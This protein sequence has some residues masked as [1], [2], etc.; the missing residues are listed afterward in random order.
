MKSAV[1]I[2]AAMLT[3]TM[4]CADLYKSNF[5]APDNRGAPRAYGFVVDLQFSENGQI[6]GEF[7]E[8]YGTSACRWN[9]V[10]L[11][12]GN[13]PDGNF[14]WLSEENT[15]RNCGRIVFIGRKEGDKIVGHLPKFQGAKVDL[16][17]SPTQ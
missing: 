7:K 12:G 8:F 15:M 14:R 13:L 16:E 6:A 11:S 1:L 10:K 3:S 9:G 4:A 5:T 17:L 2:L